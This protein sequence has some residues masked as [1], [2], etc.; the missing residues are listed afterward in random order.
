MQGFSSAPFSLWATH[1]TCATHTLAQQHKIH[2]LAC[3]QRNATWPLFRWGLMCSL[4]SVC[5]GWP[6]CRIRCCA[7]PKQREW[8]LQ[9]YIHLNHKHEQTRV[10]DD[11]S[12]L[13]FRGKRMILCFRCWFQT[14]TLPTSAGPWRMILGKSLYVCVPWFPF[15]V[16]FIRWL[17]HVAE[18]SPSLTG[19][20]YGTS[21]VFD[22]NREMLHHL[23]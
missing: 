7:P 22:Q 18:L 11:H 6:A 3:Q 17:C 21:K 23:H 2:W 8:I 20:V 4:P 1:T 13:P 9:R 15:S 19:N 16:M 12:I 14:V 10:A 5:G